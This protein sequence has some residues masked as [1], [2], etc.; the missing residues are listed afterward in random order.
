MHIL[1]TEYLYTIQLA[2]RIRETMKARWCVSIQGHGKGIDDPE[3]NECL[4][5]LSMVTRTT[6]RSIIIRECILYNEQFYARNQRTLYTTQTTNFTTAHRPSPAV[7]DISCAK[8][9]YLS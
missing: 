6:E 2:F 9:V 1:L 4:R 3:N 5:D 7:F 8:Q